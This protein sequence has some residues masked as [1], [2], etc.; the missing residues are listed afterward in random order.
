M[1]PQDHEFFLYDG[2]STHVTV[3]AIEATGQEDVHLFVLSL[4]TSHCIHPLD[5]SVFNPFKRHLTVSPIMSGLKKTAIFPFDPLH[6]VSQPP[7]ITKENQEIKGARKERNENRSVKILFQEKS[8][9][10]KGKYNLLL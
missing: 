2:H 4:Q 7:E 10:F 6:P 9:E 1:S 5:V 8:D 3:D